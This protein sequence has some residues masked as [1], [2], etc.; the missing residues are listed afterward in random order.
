MYAFLNLR[1]KRLRTDGWA[2]EWMYSDDVVDHE[3][4]RYETQSYTLFFLGNLFLINCSWPNL[5]YHFRSDP[6]NFKIISYLSH[7]STSKKI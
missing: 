6:K 5:R 7:G 1:T 3:V 2:L 4:P